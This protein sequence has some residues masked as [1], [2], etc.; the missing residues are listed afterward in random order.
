M[1]QTIVRIKTLSNRF[2]IALFLKYTVFVLFTFV[3]THNFGCANMQR[4]TGGPK[5]SI[6][7]KI[8]NI[9]PE[10]YSTNF[11]DKE[12]VITFDEFIKLNNQFKEFSI[13]P[14]TEIQPI[15]RVKKKNLHITLPDSLEENSTYTLNFGDGI[16]DYNEGNILKNF[17]YVF[18]TGNVL[19]SLSISGRVEDG[20]KKSFKY[21]DD[22]DVRVV[23]IPVSQDSIFGKKKANI[24]TSVD[25]TGNFKIANLKENTYRI[26]A[27]KEQDNDR[28]Y[29]NPNESIGFLMD[30]IVLSK[31]TSNI[32]LEYTKGYP[33]DF[34]TIER[35]IEKDGSV[36]ITFNKPLDN[37]EINIIDPQDLN[38][39]KIINYSLL[40]DTSRIFIENMDFDSIKFEIADNSAI[41]DTIMIRKGRNQKFERTIEPILNINNKVDKITHITITSKYPIQEIDKNKLILTEDSVDRRNF[42]LIK[43]ENKAN[44]YSVKYNWKPNKNYELKLEERAILS[45]FDDF[46]KELISKFTL[47]EN[48]NYGDIHFTIKGL[49]TLEQYIVE[50]IDEKK[51]NV[52][53]RKILNSNKLSFLKFPGGKYSLRIIWDQNK[54]GRWDPGDVY[55]RKQAEPIWYL[56]RVYTVRANWEQNEEIEVKF[57]D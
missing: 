37:P 11:S 53:D 12:I 29:N 23:L 45:P 39:S 41:L 2:K 48:D 28:I 42:S 56:D 13:S 44:T 30:S 22:K 14:D 6:P 31:D 43:E 17:V 33:K 1:I 27:L 35:T 54:N 21:E 38:D 52:Y 34:R 51:E 8:L 4:P 36:L 15:Y 18:A 57:T 25:S 19:D 26:Y 3:I 24:F 10:N 32:K 16:V 46:N 20:F 40:K 55:T 47:D 50:V 49:D 7:P 5:D 9:S